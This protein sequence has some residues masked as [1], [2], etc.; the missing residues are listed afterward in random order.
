MNKKFKNSKK[1]KRQQEIKTKQEL[2]KFFSDYTDNEL[3]QIY[4]WL[5]N[6]PQKI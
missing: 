4:D 5:L 1:V 2:K 3:N 6:L